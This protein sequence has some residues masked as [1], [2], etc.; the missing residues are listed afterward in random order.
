MSTTFLIFIGILL[1]L[2]EA[3]FSG[4]EIAI[5]SANRAVM[6]SPCGNWPR[7]IR[8]NSITGILDVPFVAIGVRG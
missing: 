8:P 5:I 6:S 2:G 1:L 4:S 7:S 3:V